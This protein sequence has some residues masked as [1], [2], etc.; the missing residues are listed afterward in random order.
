M[1]HVPF[2]SASTPRAD[3]FQTASSAA[4]ARDGSAVQAS[5]ASMKIR[6]AVIMVIGG[7]SEILPMRTCFEQWASGKMARRHEPP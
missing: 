2:T 7:V 6:A 1:T 5:P 3:S 4:M